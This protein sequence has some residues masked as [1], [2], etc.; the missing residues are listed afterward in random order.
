M[1]GASRRS[2]AQLQDRLV[3]APA[4]VDGELLSAQLLSVAALSGR[5]AALRAAL[6][7]P[8][9]EPPARAAIARRL[10]EARIGAEALAVVLD[11]VSA[12]WSAPR[13]LVQALE[14]L[15]FTSAFLSAERAGTLDTVEDELFRFGR[16]VVGELD[17]RA[18]LDDGRIDGDRKVAILRTL[19]SAR[20]RPVTLSLLEYLA[21]HD[22]SRRFL[23]GVEVLSVLAAQ[24][25]DEL[26]A[27]V[28][29]AAPMEAEQ[30]R[31]LAQS[32]GRIYRRTRVRLQV[33]VD[34][35]LLGGAV[36]KVGNDIIDGTVADRLDQARRRLAG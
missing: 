29:V 6:T 12:T 2:L 17:L 30:E 14:T 28:S 15:G 23:A 8:G 36:V 26:L 35:A 10:L 34:P 32:L 33:A 18:V 11:A 31:R 16:T 1:Q 20:V 22:R 24:R 13:D 4:V 25:R 9:A 5:E 27:E 19:L 3:A 7:D 21:R